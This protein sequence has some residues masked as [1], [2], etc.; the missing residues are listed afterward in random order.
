MS[1]STQ[2]LCE[3]IMSHK[4]LLEWTDIC[5]SQ[6]WSHN[7]KCRTAHVAHTVHTTTTRFM[8]HNQVVPSRTTKFL[9]VWTHLYISQDHTADL[10]T[11]FQRVVSRFSND[12]LNDFLN[13]ENGQK[14][15][16]V[17]CPE[18]AQ[19]NYDGTQDIFISGVVVLQLCIEKTNLRSD[20]TFVHFLGSYSRK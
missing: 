16:S 8:S 9:S 20:Y 15:V 1:E 11:L 3:T 5:G 13:G 10:D 2:H 4:F 17:L 14:W 12:F 19:A 6:S 7:I 18:D